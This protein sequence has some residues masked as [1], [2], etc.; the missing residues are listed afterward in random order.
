MTDYFFLIV[1]TTWVRGLALAVETLVKRPVTALRPIFVNLLIVNSPP[2]GIPISGE[3]CE[4]AIELL[5][6]PESLEAAGL[7]EGYQG[8]YA[9]SSRLLS[10][11]SL[12]LHSN[13]KSTSRGYF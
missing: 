3:R 7:Q 12:N 11:R 13:S 6:E 2:S 5:S 8:T 9:L 4:I 1:S 10:G